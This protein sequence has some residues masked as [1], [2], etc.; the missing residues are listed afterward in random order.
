M[1]K[2][3]HPKYEKVMVTC[4]CGNSFEAKSTKDKL[5]VEICS[6]CHPFYT[7]KQKILDTAGRVEKFNRRYNKKKTET[8]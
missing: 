2:E 6:D 1:K 3:T 8:E 5:I 4:A 7:G